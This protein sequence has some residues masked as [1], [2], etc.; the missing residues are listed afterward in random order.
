MATLDPDQLRALRVLR[1][2]FGDVEVLDVLNGC[3]FTRT[4]Q[5]GLR[6]RQVPRQGDPAQ[7]SLLETNNGGP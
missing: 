1:Y 4:P 3:Q 5:A 7:T 6:R 2:W